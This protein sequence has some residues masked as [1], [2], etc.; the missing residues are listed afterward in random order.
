MSLEKRSEDSVFPL[1]RNKNTVIPFYEFLG[2]SK[3]ACSGFGRGNRKQRFINEKSTFVLMH[4]NE[5]S[6][7]NIHSVGTSRLQA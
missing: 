1:R 6:E 7:G 4:G 3:A 2:W 5:F